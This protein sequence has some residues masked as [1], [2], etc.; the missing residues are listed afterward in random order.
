MPPPSLYDFSIPVMTRSLRN[1]STLLDIATDHCSS[2]GVSHSTLISARLIPDM[3]PLPFQ[4]QS[5]SDTAR[6]VAFRLGGH[7]RTPM[8]DTEST[9]AEL[10]E[11]ISKTLDVLSNV[12]REAFEGKEEQIIEIRTAGGHFEMKGLEYLQEF[13]LPNFFFHVVTAYDI[14]RANGVPVGKQDYLGGLVRKS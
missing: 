10:Q 6:G 7:P 14:L 8:A 2:S 4:I 3:N 5:A 9:F 11:R 13:A 12:K 1:L